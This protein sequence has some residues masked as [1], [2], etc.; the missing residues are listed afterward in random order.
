MTAIRTG[1]SE[2]LCHRFS[3]PQRFIFVTP[4]NVG[5]VTNTDYWERLRAGVQPEHRTVVERQFIR[6][7]LQLTAE[8]IKHPR[9]ATQPSRSQ[10]SDG[11]PELPARQWRSRSARAALRLPPG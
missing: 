4:D 8:F 6:W 9:A 5:V 3:L 10:G 2:S 11:R 1:G 7:L